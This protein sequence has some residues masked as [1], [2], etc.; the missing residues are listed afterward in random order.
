MN[1]AEKTIWSTGWLGALDWPDTFQNH[2]TDP[3]ILW[4]LAT[5]FRDFGRQG[6]KPGVVNLVAELKDPLPDPK[7]ENAPDEESRAKLFLHRLNEKGDAPFLLKGYIPDAYWAPYP[8]STE[9]ETRTRFVTLR[10]DVAAA[11]S[12]ISGPAIAERLMRLIK[13]SSIR[14]VQ[15]GHPRSNPTS[16]K[17]TGTI[18]FQQPVA[19]TPAPPV[20]LAA[21]EDTCP[22]FHEALRADPRQHGTQVAVLWDQTSIA[23]VAC[24]EAPKRFPYGRQWLKGNLDALQGPYVDHEEDL[25]EAWEQMGVDKGRFASLRGRAS[26]GAAVLG[27]LAGRKVTAAVPMDGVLPGE[28][29]GS[30]L[31]P[32]GSSDDAASNAP[33]AVVQLPR[34]QTQVS[35]GRWLAPNVLDAL[36]YVMLWAWTFRSDAAAAPPPLVVNVS[37][38]SQTGPHDGTGILEKAMEEMCDRYGGDLALVLAAGNSGGTQRDVEADDHYLPGGIHAKAELKGAAAKT[39]FHLRAPPDKQNETAL[40]IWFH[41]ALKKEDE[42]RFRV[43]KPGSAK[44]G[45]SD[46]EITL[47]GV[48]WLKDGDGKV[49]AGLIGLQRVPQAMERSMA[50]LMLAP[51]Q[52]AT[53]HP[54]APAGVWT[55][56]IELVKG[57][58]LSVDAWVERDD[59]VVGATRGQQARLLPMGMDGVALTDG[60]TFTHMATNEKTFAVTALRADGS[61]SDYS[62]TGTE[63]RKPDLSA[64]VDPLRTAHGMRVMGNRT[65]VVVRANGTSMAAPQAARWMANRL[66]GT[67]PQS[68][69]HIRHEIKIDAERTTRVGKVVP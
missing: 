64:L 1:A 44:T 12:E 62:S 67:P 27:V 57:E 50:L 60:N 19:G 39:T 23:R 43:W 58:A 5:E 37:Y 53:R 7:A 66:A 17:G 54:E 42:V 6:K 59:T 46:L 33:L 52:M 15:L 14:R 25:V 10:L 29:D 22:F 32:P 34:E 56:E 28:G 49:V 38:G 2:D 40:E 21:V 18:D 45:A 13:R 55:I 69:A 35:S 47:P 61:P 20:L 65:G 11:E 26:H 8:T 68:L 3:Y 31:M 4:A 30:G 41:R 51:T 24:P 16:Q 63:N 9:T 36:R 48:H